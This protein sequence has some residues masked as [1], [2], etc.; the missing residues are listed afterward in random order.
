MLLLVSLLVGLFYP[1]TGKNLEGR[2]AED[3]VKASTE[4]QLENCSASLLLAKNGEIQ[5]TYNANRRQAVNK[6]NQ[7]AFVYYVLSSIGTP[8][9]QP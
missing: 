6:L 5:L 1:L 2:A 4:M 8:R 7:W 9:P 3:G